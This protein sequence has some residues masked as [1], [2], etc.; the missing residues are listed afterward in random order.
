MKKLLL[1]ILF[2]SLTL[3]SYSQWSRWKRLRYEVCIGIGTSSFMGDLGGGKN[4]DS[5][6][7]DYFGD[8]DFSATRPSFYVG[9]RYKLSPLFSTKV[10]LALG[11]VTGND[12][13]STD[14]GRQ[15][16]NLNFSSVIFEQSAVLEMNIIK[17]NNAKRWSKR[18]KKRVRA[19]SV[20]L[21]T[22]L[23]VG[24]F[25]FSPQAYVLD[26][27][28]DK[29]WYN[30][31]DIGTEGQTITGNNYSRYSVCIPFGLGFKYGLN[32]KL[33]IGVEYG[34]R[35]TFTDY[36]DDVGGSYY[37]NLAIIEK[38]GGN[39][40]AGYLADHRT[41]PETSTSSFFTAEDFQS[42]SEWEAYGNYYKEGDRKPI[43]ADSPAAKIRSGDA[44]DSYMFL[45]V[46][47]SYKLRTTRRGL[48]KFR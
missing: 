36:I 20:N 32:R 39:V 41:P 2:F 31:H 6:L 35:Y 21:Y 17:E 15:S 47:L 37:D 19:Y 40:D 1:Y 43:K 7:D 10:N 46:N 12:K 9:G 4:S 13:W 45:F 3:S 11:W 16:R 23:G 27:E 5:F 30:L 33:D 42:G 8:F 22:F 38:N 25:Y 29:V 44:K 26:D 48:P 28:G 14:I 18:R 24:G 34:Y